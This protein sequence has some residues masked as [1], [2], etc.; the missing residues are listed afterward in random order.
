MSKKLKRKNER[1]R[2]MKKYGTYYWHPMYAIVE[3]TD[4]LKE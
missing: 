1:V 4:T 3:F 2:N